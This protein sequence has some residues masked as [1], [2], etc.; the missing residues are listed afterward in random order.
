MGERTFGL[1]IIGRL[2]LH[3]RCVAPTHPTRPFHV[4]LL[5][6]AMS[7]V[8]VTK[9]TAHSY[10][11][12]NF[13]IFPALY[14]PGNKSLKRIRSDCN[15]RVL[16]TPRNHCAR[17]LAEACTKKQNNNNLPGNSKAL[18]ISLAV[19]LLSSSDN[20]GARLNPAC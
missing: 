10:S 13:L 12:P 15:L 17:E 9:S 20:N 1:R 19:R 14:M 11:D 6:E 16:I 7:V 3:F 5:S 8:M 18:L 4:Q 2:A